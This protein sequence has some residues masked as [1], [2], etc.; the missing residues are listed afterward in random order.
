MRMYEE[1]IFGKIST[2]VE[3]LVDFPMSLGTIKSP[4]VVLF[5]SKAQHPN[6]G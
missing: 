2:L 6:Q 3:E 1:I 5:E 4:I